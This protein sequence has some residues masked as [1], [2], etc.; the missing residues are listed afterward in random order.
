MHSPSRYISRKR[1]QR[2]TALKKG[3]RVIFAIE[4]SGGPVFWSFSRRPAYRCGDVAPAERRVQRP[5]VVAQFRVEKPAALGPA[6]WIQAAGWSPPI[7]LPPRL[8]EVWTHWLV[9]RF[10]EP[11]QHP[12]P[13]LPVTDRSWLCQSAEY[14]NSSP[15]PLTAGW[16]FTPD[17][18][19]HAPGRSSESLSKSAP[20]SCESQ[21]QPVWWTRRGVQ[22][23]DTATM[24][25]PV[26]D[27]FLLRFVEDLAELIGVV[28]KEHSIRRQPIAIE[29]A[30]CLGY[31]HDEPLVLA[32]PHEPAV[33][34]GD[35]RMAIPAR[36]GEYEH[37]EQLVG[38]LRRWRI[39]T[40]YGCGSPS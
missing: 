34:P 29:V 1:G 2:Q 21:G 15:W 24:P 33:G 27:R 17:Q 30:G 20:P 8:F 18:R 38:R 39:I 3:T 32:Q 31:I 11:H 12:D 10:V 35:L 28:Q 40:A 16:S 22:S 25:R 37:P 6:S 9:G 14:Q 26:L 4:F 36:I 19:P 7:G 5:Q 23:D 13:G